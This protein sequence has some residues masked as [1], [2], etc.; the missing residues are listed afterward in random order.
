MTT[1]SDILAHHAAAA[2][3]CEMAPAQILGDRQRPDKLPSFRD[4]RDATPR[5][6]VAANHSRY[7]GAS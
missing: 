1:G 3:R 5:K 2:R 7:A 6:G 4:H